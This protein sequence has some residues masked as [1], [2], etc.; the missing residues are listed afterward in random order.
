M[1]EWRW[2]RKWKDFPFVC[3]SLI[4]TAIFA[5]LM[6][7]K[8]SYFLSPS[9]LAHLLSCVKCIYME[10]ASMQCIILYLAKRQ[11]IIQSFNWK[12]SLS[13]SILDGTTIDCVIENSPWSLH[14]HVW[15][16]SLCQ[17]VL[18]RI[19]IAIRVRCEGSH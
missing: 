8:L 14:S 19:S 2:R 12:N 5:S 7:H 9:P 11:K 13:Q 18:D 3:T 1:V 17:F 15:V 4:G 16:D 6:V 10:C